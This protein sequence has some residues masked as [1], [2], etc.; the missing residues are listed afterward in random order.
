M[1][2]YED[3]ICFGCGQE[4]EIGL[5]L[6]LKFDDDTKTVEYD[7]ENGNLEG[8]ST[9]K[10]FLVRIDNRILNHEIRRTNS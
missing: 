1:L 2:E 5:K 10:W 8:K 4:N 9:Y 7:K 6:E 3:K